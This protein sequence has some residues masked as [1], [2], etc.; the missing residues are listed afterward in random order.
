[1]P[2]V[3]H[4]PGP[5]TAH[6]RGSDSSWKFRH[7]ITANGKAIAHVIDFGC[8][9]Q[10]NQYAEPNHEQE[11]N[12]LLMAAAPDLLE[13]LKEMLLFVQAQRFEHNQFAQSLMLKRAEAAIRRTNHAG[14]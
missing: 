6:K 1:M 11:A 3:K 4:T 7:N 8:V 12:A 14:S 10:T 5:W 9:I 2:E 13:S